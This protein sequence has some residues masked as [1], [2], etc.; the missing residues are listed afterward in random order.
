MKQLSDKQIEYI[1]KE[2]RRSKIESSL[3]KENLI[4]HFCC[5]VEEELSRGKS[6][7]EAYDFAYHSIAPEGFEEIEQEDI[8][9]VTPLKFR[10]MKKLVYTSGYLTAT[11]LSATIVM[12]LLHVQGAQ[13]A[14]LSTAAIASFIFVPMLLTYWQRN[15]IS[16][17]SKSRYIIGYISILLLIAG[18]VSIISH[19]PG[20]LIAILTAVGIVNIALLPQFFFKQHQKNQ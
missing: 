11:L 1:E 18:T 8:L 2:I 9:L 12:K 19:W 17:V 16:K 14:L 10:I 13:I 5:A 6:F 7:N 3:L 4:D 20:G 15:Q